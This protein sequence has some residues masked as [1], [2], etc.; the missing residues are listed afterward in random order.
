MTASISYSA[1]SIVFDKPLA[2]KQAMMQSSTLVWAITCSFL[3]HALLAITLPNVNFDQVDEKPIELKIEILQPVKPI[4]EPALQAAPE[5]A[6]PQVIPPKPKKITVPKPEN[7][8]KIKLSTPQ[9]IPQKIA[10]SPDAAPKT[11]EPVLSEPA[12]Q[13]I[14]VAPQADVSPVTVVPSAPPLPEP[15]P[16]ISEE[17]INA[18]KAQYGSTLFRAFAK[19]KQYPKIAQM[20]GWQGQCTLEIKIDSAGNVQ[21]SRIKESSG[22]DVLDNQA[23]EMSKKATPFPAPPNALQGRSFTISVPISFKLE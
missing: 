13:V 22:Y 11:Q 23:V 10:P 4:I 5:P 8:P 6:K 17:D 19:H 3:L 7:K 16:Q 20:R 1:I 21:S 9:V 18:A 12:P 15:P 14:A 2:G